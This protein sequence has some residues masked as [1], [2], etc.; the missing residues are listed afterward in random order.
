MPI[1]PVQKVIKA[2]A[3]NANGITEAKEVI[4]NTEGKVRIIRDGKVQ[5]EDL[6]GE[7]KKLY[8]ENTVSYKNMRALHEQMKLAKTDE[9]RAGKRLM[10]GSFDDCISRNWKVID[11]WAAGKLDTDNL[12]AEKSGAGRF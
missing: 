12:D 8:D 4:D 11:D 6:P 7:L 1:G 9:E 10:I 5:Y 2:A 3:E